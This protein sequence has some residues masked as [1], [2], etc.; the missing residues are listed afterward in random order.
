MK[1]TLRALIVVFLTAIPLTFAARSLAAS[2]DSTIVT[3]D[4]DMPD[5]FLN[6]Y[7]ELDSE[8]AAALPTAGFPVLSIVAI[9]LFLLLVSTIPLVAALVVERRTEEA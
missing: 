9:A 8:E 7:P 6:L 2:S 4:P 5:D 1:Q 3:I